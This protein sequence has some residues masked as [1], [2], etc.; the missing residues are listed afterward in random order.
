MNPGAIKAQRALA[1]EI[2]KQH[3]C[4]LAALD[5][6]FQ[7]SVPS[8]GRPPRLR[9]VWPATEAIDRDTTGEGLRALIR[10]RGRDLWSYGGEVQLFAAMRAIAAARPGRRSWNQMQLAALWA[11]IGAAI[12]MG[13]PA[14]IVDL[15]SH[16][17]GGKLDA[18]DLGPPGLQPAR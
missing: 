17:I 14:Q 3:S 7:H 15:P 4:I 9:L 13:P 1:A 2:E 10:Y 16:R 18:S 12:D 5:K 8:D 6:L 11:D